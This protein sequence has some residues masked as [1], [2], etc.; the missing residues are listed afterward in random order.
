MIKNKI[1]LI[2]RKFWGLGGTIVPPSYIGLNIPAER[3]L[4]KFLKGGFVAG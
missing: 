1:I 2:I 3:L 4:P